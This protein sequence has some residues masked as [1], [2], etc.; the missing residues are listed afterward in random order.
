MG[1]LE[2]SGWLLQGIGCRDYISL[3]LNQQ[4]ITVT[5]GHPL[6]SHQM[7]SPNLAEALTFP[8]LVEALMCGEERVQQERGPVPSPSQIVYL[9]ALLVCLHSL[10]LCAQL[11]LLTCL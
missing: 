7:P 11:L 10:P 6:Q 2:A 9:C 5:R 3:V 4:D 1:F 8:H